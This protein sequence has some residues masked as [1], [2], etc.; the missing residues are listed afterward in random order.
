[1][2]RKLLVCVVGGWRPQVKLSRLDI[3]DTGKHSTQQATQ[4]NRL[5]NTGFTQCTLPKFAAIFKS[6]S[7]QLPP[8]LR[9]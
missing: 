4:T 8:D 9:S 7:D 1:M 3:R 6:N 2:L 5:R